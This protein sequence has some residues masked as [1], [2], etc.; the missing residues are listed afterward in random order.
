M[1][2]GGVKLPYWK[3]PAGDRT[4]VTRRKKSRLQ[5]KGWEGA[6]INPVYLPSL[7]VVVGL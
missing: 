2:F 3:G 5:V 1:G 6:T 7:I 4:S